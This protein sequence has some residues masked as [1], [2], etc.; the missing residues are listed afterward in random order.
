MGCNCTRWGE[1]GASWL[2]WVGWF[3]GVWGLVFLWWVVCGVLVCV[4]VC[5]LVGVVVKFHMIAMPFGVRV[6][7]RADTL[8]T[9]FGYAVFVY[10]VWW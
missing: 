9:W 7:V 6:V 1:S 8:W 4:L 3:V 2:F 5:G 10:G